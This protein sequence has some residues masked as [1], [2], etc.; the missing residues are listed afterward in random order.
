MSLTRLFSYDTLLGAMKKKRGREG[1]LPPPHS[2]RAVIIINRHYERHINF[3]SEDKGMMMLYPVEVFDAISCPCPSRSINLN[4]PRLRRGIR[5]T[6][7]KRD[8]T[9][10]CSRGPLS[11]TFTSHSEHRFNLIQEI[12]NKF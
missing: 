3:Q 9:I 6:P 5:F 8:A 11:T 12:I 2:S 4:E 7:T 10:D 1:T